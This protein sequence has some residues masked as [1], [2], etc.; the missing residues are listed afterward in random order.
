MNSLSLPDL[1]HVLTWTRPLWEDVRQKRLFMTG[2]TGF[3]GCWLLETF[4]HANEQLALGAEMHVLTR[5]IDS[6]HKKAPH[7]A[8]RVFLHHGDVRSFAFPDGPFSYLIHAAT[9]ASAKLN[10]EE[11]LLMLD[12]V[13][14]GTRRTLEFARCSGAESVLLA[15]SGAVYGRQTVPDVPE[16]YEGAPD[17]L[18]PRS[19]YG[20][21]KRLAELLCALYQ[22]H[23]GIS[24]KIARCFA[25][26]G[27][28]LP[29]DRHFAIGNFI[30]NGLSGEPIKIAGDGTPYRSYLYAA[31]LAIWLWTILLRGE[32]GRP[33]NVGSEHAVT[34]RELAEV[35]AEQF[36]GTEV[37]VAQTPPPGKIG[38]RYLPSTERARAE[39][40][41]LDRIELPEA[42]RRTAEWHRI[43]E[44]EVLLKGSTHV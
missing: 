2:G 35:V 5:D 39:L 1:N 43:S 29:L 34:I 6:F 40:G 7:L 23:F 18:D 31:D 10:A 41:L 11:G 4:L 36:P 30:R 19:A 28:Y 3:F 24:T 26:V 33:Y 42:I 21:G 14:E 25:F 15:S 16:S 9:E 17:C 8:E 22:Q 13:V 32:P 37:Q 44:R 27:P 20:E 12:T 38:E